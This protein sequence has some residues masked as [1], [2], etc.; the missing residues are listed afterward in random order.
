MDGPPV[1][2]NGNGL[3]GGPMRHDGW[4]GT[5][6]DVTQAGQPAVGTGGHA[7]LDVLW[8]PA[9]LV[10]V[11]LGGL[12]LAAVLALAPG[13]RGDRLVYFGMLALLVQWILLLSLAALY[14][15]RGLLR[16]LPPQAIAALALAVLL[17]ATWFVGIVGSWL[18]GEALEIDAARPV[19]QLVRLSA[20][21]LVVGLLGVAAFH[22][23]WRARGLAI[24]AKQAELEAL[25]AR[26]RPHF[27][28]NALN[29]G[30]ALVH[31]RPS[32]AEQVLLD[33]SD[34]FRA[35]LAGPRLIPLA[36]ELALTRRYLEI[37]RLRYGDRLGVSWDV[38]DAL[39]DAVVPSLSIQPLA[40]NAIRHGIEGLPEGGIVQVE[41]RVSKDAVEVAV[42]NPLPTTATNR[43][44]HGV[45]LGGVRASLE[46]LT[47]GRGRIE[48]R[49]AAGQYVA[50]LTVPI[51]SAGASPT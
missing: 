17:A 39:P 36:D 2:P 42:S 31:A 46:A 37:E 16:R 44:G 6:R 26:T 19:S 49:E 43:R 40:E 20:I 18:V 27:L 41:V 24:R 30:I 14:L 21:V 47:E 1:G 12:G 38:P 7:P 29:T 8:Q 34:L 22:N 5:R 23:H 48:T 35:A 25:Q 33:L 15:L 28:F 13:V 10:W 3:G 11:V 50:T 32:D 9:T 51:L 4:M 45:G